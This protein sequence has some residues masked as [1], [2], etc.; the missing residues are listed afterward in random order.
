MALPKR[1]HANSRTN[2]RRNHQRLVAPAL[3]KCGHCKAHVR[4]HNAC[5][6][7]GYYQGE[8]VDHTVTEKPSARG[9][10]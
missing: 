10:S 6:K 3:T 7:C 5:P 1:R 4:T 2:K 9:G 8:H